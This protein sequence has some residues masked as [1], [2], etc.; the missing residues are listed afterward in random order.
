MGKGSK[1]AKEVAKG[2]NARTL[3][4]LS[5]HWFHL[6]ELEKIFFKKAKAGEELAKMTNVHI[7]PALPDCNC[8][9][10]RIFRKNKFR[11]D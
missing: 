11:S 8:D 9:F 10:C 3:N 5:R 2:L 1:S 7:W 6:P 4:Q